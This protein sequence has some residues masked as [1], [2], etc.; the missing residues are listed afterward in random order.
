MSPLIG[1]PLEPTTNAIL[2]T[3]RC[4]GGDNGIVYVTVPITTGIREFQLMKRLSCSREMLRTSFKKDWELAVK[5]PNQADAEAY[6]LMV[7]LR[8]P[9]RLVLNPAALEVE[10]WSQDQYTEMWNQVLVEFCDTLVV[11]PDWMFSKGAREEVQR[12]LLLGRE[13]VDIFGKRLAPDMLARSDESMKERLVSL[14]WDEPTIDIML[15]PM[16]LPR[17]TGVVTRRSQPD[18]DRAVKWILDERRWQQR[19]LEFDDDKRTQADGPRGKAGN[20]H[21]LMSKYYLRAQEAGIE[22]ESGGTN[23]MI[24]ASLAVAHLESVMD[25]FGPLPEPG[26]SSGETPILSRIH[27]PEL[28]R[29]DRLALAVAWLRREHFYTN[30]KYPSDADDDNTSMGIGSGSWWDRQLKMYWARAFESGLD[31]LSGRQQLG[32]FATTALNLATSR[33]RLFGLPPMPTRRTA[34]ELLPF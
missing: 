7:K 21:A 33:V 19:I 17:G 20:W 29:N 34:E 24:Y 15:P 27:P 9:N 11:T 5:H 16:K 1:A 31:T 23:L 26:F 4:L 12:M 8:Y 14:G 13:V 32:K 3:I 22:T 2:D 28:E 10:M 18:W 30:S 25:V 6:A